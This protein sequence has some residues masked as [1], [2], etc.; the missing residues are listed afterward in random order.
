MIETLPPLRR[1]L[2]YVPGQHRTM[3]E[4]GRQS[5]ADVVCLD[6]EDNVPPGE[7][8]SARAIVSEAANLGGFAALELIVRIN[9]SDPEERALD[10]EMLA[11]TLIRD[12]MVPKVSTVEDLAPIRARLGGGAR[13]LR[14]WAM[15]ETARGLSNCEEIALVEDVTALVIGAGDLAAD[16]RLPSADAVSGLHLVGT[17]VVVAARAAGRCAIEGITLPVTAPNPCGFDGRST[18]I[19]QDIAALNAVFSPTPDEVDH[20]RAALDRPYAYGDHLR[21]ARRTLKLARR[22]AERDASVAEMVG[23]GALEV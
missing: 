21:Y 2:V 1:S 22:A 15:I 7:K 9:A 14:L 13:P 16:L 10:L 23:L 19:G 18:F 8:P 12:I 3:V 17:R 5:L 6:L 11:S 4:Q 20:A